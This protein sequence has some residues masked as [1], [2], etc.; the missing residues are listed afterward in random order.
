MFRLVPSNMQFVTSYQVL[1]KNVSII[2]SN[3]TD[4]SCEKHKRTMDGLKYL[5]LDIE[6]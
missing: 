4:M 3:G 6:G 5:Q 2:R 1:L